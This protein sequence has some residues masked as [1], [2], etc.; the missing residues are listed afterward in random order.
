[1]RCRPTGKG[2][3]RAVLAAACG[4]A[5]IGVGGC[6]SGRA[7]GSGVVMLPPRG[8]PS[9]T[10]QYPGLIAP[11]P[12]SS[13]AA[14]APAPAKRAGPYAAAVPVSANPRTPSRPPAG[15]AAA[16]R[17]RSGDPIII[18]LRGIP[19]QDQEL[20]DVVDESGN[21]SLPYINMVQA[22]GKTTT[23]IEQAIRKAYVDQQIYKQINVSVV[24]PSRSYFVRGEIRQAGRFPLVTGTT[25]VQAIAAAGGFTEFA[26]VS[27]VEVI[28]GSQRFRVNVRDLEKRPERDRE[29]EAGDVIIVH[30]SFF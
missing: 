18:Y 8:A 30:R 25:I 2:C 1:M 15:A 19:G 20:S 26:D 27:N 14:A 24:M 13:Q 29:V 4:A 28:R 9:A 7:Q 21:I 3:L 12:A 10:S 23:E 17:L 11:A 22:G 6:A 16:Y 5:L